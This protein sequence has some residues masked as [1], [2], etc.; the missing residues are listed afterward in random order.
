[1]HYGKPIK[2]ATSYGFVK[3]LTDI[4]FLLIIKQKTSLVS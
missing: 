2:S 4:N 3:G 1:M